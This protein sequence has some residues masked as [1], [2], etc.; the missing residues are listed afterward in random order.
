MLNSC[1]LF[2]GSL[3]WE[4]GL[5]DL[6]L[7]RVLPF[8]LRF[9]LRSPKAHRHP[10]NTPKIVFGASVSF[11]IGVVFEVPCGSLP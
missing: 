7:W 4:L 6:S 1:G 3:V 5:L 8:L 9:G 11:S 2:V 10:C